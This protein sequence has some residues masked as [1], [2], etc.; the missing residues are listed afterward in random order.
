MHYKVTIDLL[1]KAERLLKWIKYFP[2]EIQLIWVYEVMLLVAL[3]GTPEGD[4]RLDEKKKN[5][6]FTHEDASGFYNKT[7]Y[8]ILFQRLYNFR[9]RFIH[10]G[11]VSGHKALPH[12]KAVDHRLFDEFLSQFK[13][14]VIMN[15]NCNLY[16]W[17]PEEVLRDG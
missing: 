13:T 6:V 7:R 2:I 16:I 9:S 15:W 3:N 4:R 10:E 11:P 1:L 17:I 5:Y 14:E 12:V 8:R